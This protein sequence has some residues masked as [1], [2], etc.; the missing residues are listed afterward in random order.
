MNSDPTSATAAP[1]DFD[2]SEEPRRAR[3]LATDDRPEML[4]LIDRLLGGRYACEFA[5]SVEEAR[6]KLAGADV[7]ELALCD[8]QMPKRVRADAG[9]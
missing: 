2:G 7:F 1:T 5:G 4:R 3:V 8:I 6:R 9:S